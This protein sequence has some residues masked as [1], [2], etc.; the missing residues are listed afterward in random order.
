M[1]LLLVL[2]TLCHVTLPLFLVHV[3]I[4]LLT[5]IFPLGEVA[6]KGQSA[7]NKD[8]IVLLRFTYLYVS[9]EAG[10]ENEVGIP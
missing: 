1:I 7:E 4:E 2:S 5:S 9:K 10:V 8:K 3:V 6:N